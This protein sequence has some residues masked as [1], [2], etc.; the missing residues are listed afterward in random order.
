MKNTL[1]ALALLTACAGASETDNPAEPL[2][3]GFEDTPNPIFAHPIDPSM[4]SFF[5]REPTEVEKL[6]RPGGYGAQ[7]PG[8]G[9]GGIGGA[10]CIVPWNWGL[11]FVAKRKDY[12]LKFYASTCNSWWQGRV[13]EAQA[14]LNASNE[15]ATGFGVENVTFDGTHEIE[16]R[17]GAVPSGFVAYT[18]LLPSWTDTLVSD[19]TIRQYAKANTVI[20]NT[21][22]EGASAWASATE[23][24]RRNIARNVIKHEMAHGF[25]GLGHVVNGGNVLMQTAFQYTNPSGYAWASSLNITATEKSWLT[26]FVP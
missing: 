21:I 2:D 9:G 20:G 6:T 17:C 26:S 3:F 1:I 22:V 7:S 14:E 19:G 18:E 13:V 25:Y 10:D 16:I 24:Q 12:R 5:L 8:A 23:T 11:C 15:A 4:P